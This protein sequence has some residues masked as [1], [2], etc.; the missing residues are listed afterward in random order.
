MGELVAE[1]KNIPAI[2]ISLTMQSCRNLALMSKLRG[3]TKKK[4]RYK[5]R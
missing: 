2:L 4:H 3:V 5:W 1:E